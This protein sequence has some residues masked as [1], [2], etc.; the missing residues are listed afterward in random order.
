V[1]AEVKAILNRQ[2]RMLRHEADDIRAM[3]PVI[4]SSYY[5]SGDADL[6]KEMYGI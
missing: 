2:E 3:V 4:G 1:L 5:W 6:R